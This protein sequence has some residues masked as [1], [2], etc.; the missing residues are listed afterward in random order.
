MKEHI[1]THFP[2][3]VFNLKFFKTIYFCNSMEQFVG[4]RN[5]IVFGP[6]AIPTLLIY[7]TLS[8]FRTRM[9]IK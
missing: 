2:K 9:F 3:I 4:Q 8:K 1:F 5:P 6:I 7:D